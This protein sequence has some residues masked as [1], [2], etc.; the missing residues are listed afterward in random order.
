MRTNYYLHENT[1]EHCGRSDAPLHIGKSSFGWCFALRVYP[2]QGINDLSDW[3]KYWENG[4]IKSEHG[5]VI[6]PDGMLSII[7]ERYGSAAWDER[8][9]GDGPL[10]YRCEADML[11]KK[12]AQRGPNNLLRHR[13]GR[14]VVGHGSGTWDL[15]EG[16]FS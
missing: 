13:I 7:T 16:D 5:D 12:F 2:D 6:S 9:Y 8:T 11:A 3:C 14:D 15:I 1:C 10:Q 4:I